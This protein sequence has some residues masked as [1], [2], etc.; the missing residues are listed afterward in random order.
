M[1][2][3]QVELKAKR[4]EAVS[5]RSPW[6]FSGAIA[7]ASNFEQD[8]QLC[9]VLL[10]GAV[11]A[12]GYLNT[13]T[14]IAVRIFEY[15]DLV[16]DQRFFRDRIA[17]SRV[18]REQLV[19]QHSDSYRIINAEGDGLPGL[20]VDKYGDYLVLQSSTAG[21]DLLKETIVAALV[22][23]FQPQGI[24]E[25]SR[26]ATRKLEGLLPVSGV[27][28]G[29]IPPE[30][31]INEHG[32]R[33]AVDI[34]EGQKTGFFLDQR[35]NRQIIAAHAKG[36]TALN[37]YCYSAAI[38]VALQRGGVGTLHNVDISESALALAAR[39]YELNGIVPAADEFRPADVK[40][41]LEV[42]PE[43]FYD[44]IILDPPKF[45]ATKRTVD[46]A[47]KGYKHINLAALRKIRSGGLLFT[48]SCSGLIDGELFRKIIFYAAK[49]AGRAVRV[50]KS[51][52]ADLDH[53]ASVYHRESDYLK[54]LM[55]YV[56]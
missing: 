5:E 43:N 16:I 32:M 29:D 39:N 51:L 10:N 42:M 4:T 45:T 53:P 2:Y 52:A 6:I 37:C 41:Y 22:A 8:G 30:V 25:K 13:R 18:M 9:R 49:D 15:A 11:V 3:A 40:E 47:I 54:G 21:I 26:S 23:V 19:G 56:A 17:A 38:G 44:L 34:P 27:L 28:Y 31:I 35:E 33:F 7:E 46:S 20:I 48:F 50:V 36:R 1:H 14:T 12:T 24:Y 55:L